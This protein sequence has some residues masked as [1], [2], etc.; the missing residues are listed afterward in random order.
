MSTSELYNIA[1]DELVTELDACLS[2]FKNS[3]NRELYPIIVKHESEINDL[4]RV[5]YFDYK[6]DDFLPLSSGYWL[7]V[8]EWRKPSYQELDTFSAYKSDK[9]T[10]AIK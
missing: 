9:L 2:K 8:R 6:Q 10:S 7:V 5:G 4:K 1:I 3:T